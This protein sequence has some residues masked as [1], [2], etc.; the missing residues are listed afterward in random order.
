[1]A[2]LAQFVGVRI[3]SHEADE[4]ALIAVRHFADAA[5]DV[6]SRSAETH[7]E[8]QG[9]LCFEFLSCHNFSPVF[10]FKFFNSYYLNLTNLPHCEPSAR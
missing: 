5:D 7:K 10:K 8:R 9:Q 4:L 1:M 2:Q 3:E 6:A